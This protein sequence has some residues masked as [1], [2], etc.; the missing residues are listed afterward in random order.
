MTC[1]R[2]KVY[3][4]R[5][6]CLAVFVRY[7]PNRMLL[8]Q[9]EAQT[10]PTRLATAIRVIE[11]ITDRAGPAEREDVDPG[12]EGPSLARGMIHEWFVGGLIESSRNDWP[13]LGILA[14][15]AARALEGEPGV[16]GRVLWIGRR[17]WP[18]PP[19][20]AAFSPVL[21]RRSVFVEAPHTPPAARVWAID[22]ALRCPAITAV[23]A[24]GSGLDIAATRRLQL[25]AHAGRALALI[26]RPFREIQE[27]STAATRWVVGRRVFAG[28]P[29]WTVELVRRKGV[30]H[31][32]EVGWRCGLEWDH[33]SG[34]VGVPADVVRGPGA[35][36]VEEGEIRRTA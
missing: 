33:A 29:G 24:D 30:G 28:R 3:F 10:D 36:A 31:L 12:W 4:F 19:A 16:G 18:Y 20:L 2:G 22:A 15:L 11:G 35:E 1:G 21:L 23:V 13:P 7:T 5:R 26:A 32:M 27:L 14:H 17:C 34:V 25:A 6:P 8:V 9:F